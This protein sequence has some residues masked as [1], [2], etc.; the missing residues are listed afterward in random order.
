[1][2]EPNLNSS[3]DPNSGFCSE[4]NTFFSL[5]PP[6]PLPPANLPLSVFHYVFSLLRTSSS[7]E[8]IALI[9]ST[10]GHRL[11]YSEFIRQTQNLA[12]SLQTLIGLSKGDTAFVL[13]PACLQIPILYFS[14]FSIGVV[15]SPANPTGTIP[16]IS[17]QIELCK[18]VIA[19]ATSEMADKLPSLRHQTIL[20]DSPEFQAMMTTKLGYR[21]APVEVAQSEPATILY[22]S[23]TTGSVKG[24]VLTHRNWISMVAGIYAFLPKRASPAVVLSMSPYFHV[25][26]FLHCVKSVAVGES[27]VLMKQFNVRRMTTVVEEF[28]VTHIAVAPPVVVAMVKD[29]VAMRGRDL[30]SLEVV[31]C[32]GAPLAKEVALKLK[33]RLSKVLL[34]Q[35]YGL[36][37]STG[38]V[39]RTVNLEENCP[40]GSAGR[41][42]TNYE[43]KIVDPQTGIALPPYMQGELW[44]RG[45]TI[46][47]GYI[48]DNKATAATVDPDG[49]LRTGDLCYIDNNGFLYIVDRLKELIKYKAY[50]VPPA[51]LEHLLQSH[52]DILDAAVVPFPDEEAGQVPM[53]YVVRQPLSTIDESQIIDFVSKQVAPYKMVRRVSFVTS[54]PKNAA[55]KI[56]RKELMKLTLPK[57]TSKL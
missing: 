10:T 37:E 22:S 18:P 9:D 44:I 24:V 49:W 42:A 48:G 6:V 45:P 35:A 36:T 43:A 12:T 31:F 23:G 25:Y 5:R 1:M 3:I 39:F 52:P 54:I 33:E 16:E 30:S 14:L 4:T 21:F 38:G 40:I 56:L 47:K 19:F 53:A 32:G 51:E 8:T 46:M 13:S 15:I 17:R 11:P 50:Q 2:A 57:P 28:K 55:G 29:E 41:L 34:A 27:V 7:L 20:L 26:G